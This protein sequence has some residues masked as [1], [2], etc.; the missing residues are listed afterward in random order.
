M[1][2]NI[3]RVFGEIILPLFFIEN[4]KRFSHLSERTSFRDYLILDNILWEAPTSVSF[5][6]V[7]FPSLLIVR[8][9]PNNQFFY[10]V[11]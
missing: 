9:N 11:F 4:F 6:L 7:A 3:Q 8:G 10:L 2:K 1:E 5:V